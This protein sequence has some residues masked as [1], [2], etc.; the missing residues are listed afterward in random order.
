[1]EAT[2]KYLSQAVIASPAGSLLMYRFRN[3]YQLLVT[4]L[5]PDALGAGD[6]MLSRIAGL[7]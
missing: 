3:F 7:Q 6:H 2:S 1:M 5:R 4:Q